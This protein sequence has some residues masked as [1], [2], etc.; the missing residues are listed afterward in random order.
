[1]KYRII[2]AITT[3]LAVFG[4]QADT[5]NA[6]FSG[7]A[8]TFCTIAQVSPGTLTLSTNS[9][10]TDT[11]AV[12]AVE[13]NDANIYKISATNAGDFTS[14]PNGYTGVATMTTSMTV[15]GANPGSVPSG[16]EFNLTNAGAD[17]VSV[18]ISGGATENMTA[19]NYAANS[20]VSCV[21]Q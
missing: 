4:A 21:A 8:G 20:V 15:T 9:I 16:S 13:N 12:M 1:M 10:S 2:L 3:M 18:S 5:A 7:S 14:K 11:P 19:G 6:Q 17:T